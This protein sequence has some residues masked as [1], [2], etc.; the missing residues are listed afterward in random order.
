MFILKIEKWDSWILN[1][2][3]PHG[4]SQAAAK[5]W[6]SKSQKPQR[7]TQRKERRQIRA[8]TTIRHEAR[9]AQR[10]QL[11]VQTTNRPPFFHSL[12]IQTMK[13]GKETQIVPKEEQLALTHRNARHSQKEWKVTK[14]LKIVNLILW[15]SFYGWHLQLQQYMETINTHRGKKPLNRSNYLEITIKF[16]KRWQEMNMG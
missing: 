13:K 11:I 1:K 5:V 6:K 12:N 4:T 9:R 16:Q 14:K 3:K 2:F 15:V 7:N 10:I 8:L